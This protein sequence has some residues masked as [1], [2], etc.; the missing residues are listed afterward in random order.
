MQKYK[1]TV[2]G[3]ISDDEIPAVCPKCGAT[4]EKFETLSE[5]QVKLIDRSR[6]TN[7]LHTDLM[8]ALEDIL[9]TSMEGIDD[10]LDPGCLAIFN[11]AHKS[12]LELI[13]MCKA[14]IAA[15]VSKGKWG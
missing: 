13:Q 3:Y 2:C 14:E 1:C 9:D 15:H 6:Y 5:D 7:L 10:N 12:A 8:L 4:H 11:K